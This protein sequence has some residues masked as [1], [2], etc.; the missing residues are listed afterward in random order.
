[1]YTCEGDEP[2]PDFQSKFSN[3]LDI[4]NVS[5]EDLEKALSKLKVNKSPG[6]DDL[7]PRILKELSHK[8][9]K[10]LKM[11]FDKTMIQGKIPCQWKTAEVRPIFKKGKKTTPGNNRPV[12]LTSVICK[13][14]EGF[15]RNAL[16]KHF[17]SNHLLSEHQFVRGGHV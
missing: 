17:V 3:P 11:L 12:S 10:P 14:F 15:I 5:E 6:P 2:V 9:A 16:Y 4:V 13:L 1:M 7:H 8:L